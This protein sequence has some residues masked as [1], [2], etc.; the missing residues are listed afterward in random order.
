MFCAQGSFHGGA[1]FA[2][3]LA[4]AGEA[5]QALA[6]DHQRMVEDGLVRDDAESFDALLQRCQVLADKLNAALLK[7][8]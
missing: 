7:V 2:L 6:K 5:R 1:G 4:P 3:T 8:P